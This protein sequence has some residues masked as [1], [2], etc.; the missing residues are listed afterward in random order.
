[1]NEPLVCGTGIFQYAKR[2]VD[3][4]LASDEAVGRSTLTG[5]STNPRGE[6]QTK[7]Y[8]G[9]YDSTVHFHR[10]SV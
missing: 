1:M 10:Q 9:G 5:N 4:M 7:A 3:L 8:L 2:M 6:F